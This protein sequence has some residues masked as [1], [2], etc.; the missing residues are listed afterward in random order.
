MSL[1]RIATR[2]T[3]TASPSTT[4]A[5]IARLMEEK[6]VGSVVIV[7]DVKP[8]GIV[9][10]RDLVLRV[11]GKGLDPATVLV[12]L[13]MSSHVECVSA[14]RDPVAAAVHMRQRGIR[15]LPVVGRDGELLGIVTYD[16]LVHHV[17]SQSSE[18]AAAIA[19]F[20]EAPQSD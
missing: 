8:V 12:V 14:D 9:T 13:V 7:R 20:P 6:N 2:D 4:V 16:D 5:E 11:I 1:I 19:E 15:R 10:D 18:L 17:G 3:V